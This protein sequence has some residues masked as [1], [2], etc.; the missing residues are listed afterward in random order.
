MVENSA[1]RFTG[2]EIRL[3][4]GGR[5]LAQH[6]TGL[7]VAPGLG[8]LLGNTV[9]EKGTILMI[10]WAQALAN[11][12]LEG[13]VQATVADDLAVNGTR[14]E[15]VRVGERWLVATADYG[16]QG[17]EVRLYDPERLKT[18]ART[19]EPGVLVHRFRSSPYVQTLHWLDAPGLLVLVQ[20]QQSGRGWRLTVVDLARSIEAGEQVVTLTTDQAP[21]DELEGFHLLAP[22]RGLFLTSS[23]LN[24]LYFANVRLF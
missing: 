7:T 11:G 16:A 22:G 5:S 10:D 3:T 9:A 13:A 23:P 8:T 17:N 2:R 19:S 6:P 18:A 1:L 20:N 12:T 15:F 14:P 24:N 21:P 4:A